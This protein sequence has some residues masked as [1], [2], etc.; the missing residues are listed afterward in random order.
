[1]KPAPKFSIITIT[2]NNHDGL[3]RTGK[4]ITLQSYFDYEW[5]I[6]DG[7][8]ADNTKAYLKTLNADNIIIISEPDNG[9]YDAMNKGI[10]QATGQY[11]IFMN[12]GDV[13]ADANILETIAEQE[14][15]D[16]FIYGD[17][18]EN[19]EGGNLFYKS[20]RPYTKID[21]GMITHHQAMI[22]NRD[23]ISELRYNIAYKIA[24]DYDFTRCFL[25][26]SEHVRYIPEP[27]CIF[28][29][30]GISQT[31]TRLAR[32]EQFDIRNNEISILKNR[33]VYAL[34]FITISLKAYMPWLYRI[35][36]K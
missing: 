30:G 36:R 24:A 10:D 4:S 27:I 14:S 20:A 26:Q 31:Q 2:Y 1:M 34:Q 19:N 16:D 11:L 18:L 15:N 5:I 17:A 23:L 21:Y 9:I 12:A 22:Y 13:F 6:I 29:H 28:E 33:M 3:S 8:S 35:L 7:A 25:K 32:Q